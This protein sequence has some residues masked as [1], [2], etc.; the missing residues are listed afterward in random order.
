MSLEN[1]CDFKN[2]YVYEYPPPEM[3]K[4]CLAFIE[5]YLCEFRRFQNKNRDGKKLLKKN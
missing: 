5:V 3:K 1:I 2:L 4:G